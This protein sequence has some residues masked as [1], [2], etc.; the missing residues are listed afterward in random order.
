[1]TDF[2][3]RIWDCGLR[4]GGGIRAY[5]PEGLRI[6]G[7]ASGFAF[8]YD[9]TGRSIIIMN[10]RIHYSK[11]DVEHSICQRFTRLWMAD[12]CLLASSELD[13]DFSS[14]TV[15]RLTSDL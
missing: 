12:K 11:L 6:C 15:C 5:A 9:P 4:P 2:R 7:I 14:L 13:V 3:L 10:D 8:D 1:M